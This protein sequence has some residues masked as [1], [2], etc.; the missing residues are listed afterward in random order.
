MSKSRAM[1]GANACS[2]DR[3]GRGTRLTGPKIALG[4]REWR[5]IRSEWWSGCSVR[6]EQLDQAKLRHRFRHTVARLR[7][8]RGPGS[9]NQL[10]ACSCVASGGQ[11]KELTRVQCAIA[12]D[13]SAPEKKKK[14]NRTGAGVQG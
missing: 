4:E 5:S 6:G 8:R 2:A 9:T 7:L 13:E 14:D 11:K 10:L 1:W 3:S 12:T